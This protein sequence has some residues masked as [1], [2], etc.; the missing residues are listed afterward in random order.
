MRKP[1]DYLKKSKTSFHEQ[2][3]S[4]LHLQNLLCLTLYLLLLLV[5]SKQKI[6]VIIVMHED[7]SMIN[8]ISKNTQH[9]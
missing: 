3:L 6:L 5:H 1:Y 8:K 2:I 7:I 9:C 4:K